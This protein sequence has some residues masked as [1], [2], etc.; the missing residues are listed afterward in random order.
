[1]YRKHLKHGF[2]A[3]FRTSGVESEYY[4]KCFSSD[5][6]CLYSNLFVKGA[7]FDDE[8]INWR[9]EGEEN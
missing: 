6:I 1:M 7:K 2:Q 4:W 9:E 5:S 3:A 8:W